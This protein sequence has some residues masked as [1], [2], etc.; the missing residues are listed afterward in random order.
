MGD[1]WLTTK[2]SPHFTKRICIHGTE[3][4]TG[5]LSMVN[6]YSLDV[7]SMIAELT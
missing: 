4:N 2:G 7:H 1:E 3:I 5:K 6:C